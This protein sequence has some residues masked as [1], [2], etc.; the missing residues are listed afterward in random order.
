MAPTQFRISAQ[1]FRVAM[2]VL[3]YA[4]GFCRYQGRGLCQAMDII[5]LLIFIPYFA[6][7]H[8]GKSSATVF[9]FDCIS[10]VVAESIYGLFGRLC[11]RGRFRAIGGRSAACSFGCPETTTRVNVE[12]FQ[13]PTVARTG[14]GA[15]LWYRR[16]S[17]ARAGWP[18]QAVG[19]CP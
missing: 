19:A 3:A 13:R 4:M 15:S 12:P 16:R 5:L 17:R 10:N 6:L 14:L 18:P 7:G 11:A 8:S 9:L 2:I 1:S